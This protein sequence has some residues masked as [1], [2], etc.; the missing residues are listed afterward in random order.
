[1]NFDAED[2]P[3]EEKFPVRRIRFKPRFKSDMRR[4][5]RAKIGKKT[6]EQR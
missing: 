4:S 1:M 6:K 5:A 2:S 3:A